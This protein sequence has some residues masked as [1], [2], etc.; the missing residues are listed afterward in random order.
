MED[1]ALRLIASGSIAWMKRAVRDLAQIRAR[2]FRTSAKNGAQ[3]SLVYTMRKRRFRRAF[4][5]LGAAELSIGSGET[6]GSA[7][8]DVLGIDTFLPFL[9]VPL[10]FWPDPLP[11]CFLH[12]F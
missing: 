9:E 3:V 6:E 2:T 12:P 4:E 1:A 8:S 10:P 5:C 11:T 7:D